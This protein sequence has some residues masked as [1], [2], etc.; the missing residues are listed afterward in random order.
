[1][2]RYSLINFPLSAKELDDASKIQEEID[3]VNKDKGNTKNINILIKNLK[4]K[5]VYMDDIP[6]EVIYQNTTIECTTG[7]KHDILLNLYKCYYS[8]YIKNMIDRKVI[9]KPNEAF[10]EYKLKF[11]F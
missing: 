3:C 2:S 8:I 9:E 7:E 4:T 1:M 11:F 5:Y 10:E 6:N